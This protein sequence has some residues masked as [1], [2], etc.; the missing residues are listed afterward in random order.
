VV[1]T[2]RGL[3]TEVPEAGVPQ[4]TAGRD[5]QE[6]QGSGWPCVLR[7]ARTHTLLASKPDE[8]A[9]PQGSFAPYLSPQ[10]G[11]PS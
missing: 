5:E 3:R 7:G 9:S 6:V 2:C 11:I 8:Q 1:V 4:S 10:L